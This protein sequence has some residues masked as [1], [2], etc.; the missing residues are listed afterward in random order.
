MIPDSA[1]FQLFLE[2]V[3]ETTWLELVA[4]LFGIL[5]VWFARQ[6]NLLVYPTGI[7]STVIYVYICYKFQLYAD[8][9]INVFYTS[10]SIY[11]WYVWTR[12]D[13][14]KR[15]R[16]IRWNTKFQQA[17]GIGMIPVLY[18]VIFGLIYI[19]KQN[20]PEY[21]QSYIPYVDSLTTSIFL[22]GMF[23]M[24]RKK[25]ENWIY[26][27]AGNIISIPLYFVKGLV[28]T[29]FQFTVFLVLAVMGLVA[30]I[31]MYNEGRAREQ[32]FVQD[33]V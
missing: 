30:W 4:V 10:M 9:G 16:P 22:I 15:Y 1:F 27:I 26:W 23:Y 29:S 7:V 21:M 19:F 25:I 11:G 6:A 8:M 12:K 5:S 14:L 17:I 28:F 24:A 32:K 20:D 3:K 13:E 33:L 18:A 31:R 2:N